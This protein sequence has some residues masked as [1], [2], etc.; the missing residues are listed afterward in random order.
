M[1]HLKPIPF[2]PTQ[3]MVAAAEEAYMPFGDMKLALMCA[4]HAAP[5]V[6]LSDG[7]KDLIRDI[8]MRNGFTVKEGRDDLA[9]YVYA[10]A[11]DLLQVVTGA[12]G[13][14]VAYLRKDQLRQ[15]QRMGP[16]LGEIAASPRVDR[17][18]VYT[19]PQ[20]VEQQPSAGDSLTPVPDEVFAAEFD[21]WWEE[22]GQFC[23]AGGGTYERSFAFEAWRHLYPQLMKLQ[24]AAAEHQ[25]APDVAALVEALEWLRCAIN[26]TPENDKHQIGAWISTNHPRIRQIDELLAARR[27]ITTC[28]AEIGRDQ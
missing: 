27:V 26:C 20:P 8:F 4:I 24:K 11:H 16:M 23:R 15:V 7:H 14:P 13:E 18:P 6:P 1:K 21:A 5:A 19:A 17:V 12:Q 9:D 28:A 25:P 2:E 10:A 3:E 22:R